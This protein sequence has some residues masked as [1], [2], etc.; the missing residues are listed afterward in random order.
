MATNE[1]TEDYLEEQVLFWRKDITRCIQKP[2][3]VSQL[4]ALDVISH[5][6]SM[7]LHDVFTKNIALVAADKLI[8]AVYKSKA[9]N[10]WSSFLKALD[11]EGLV[12]LKE[13]IEEG[14]HETPEEREH[15]RKMIQIFAPEL[16]RRVEPLDLLPDLISRDVIDK[17]DAEAVR[18][19]QA[20][21]GRSYA[22]VCMYRRMQS[23]LR[24][25]K[26]YY[27]FLCVLK[28]QGYEDILDIM[29]PQFLKSPT[30]Y[31]PKPGDKWIPKKPYRCND[32]TEHVL[33]EVHYPSQE[34]KLKSNPSIWNANLN[35]QHRSPEG[36]LYDRRTEMMSLEP[37]TISESTFHNRDRMHFALAHKVGQDLDRTN[38]WSRR[39]SLSS[40][41]I[42]SE[43]CSHISDEASTYDGPLHLQV[44]HAKRITGNR[45]DMRMNRNPEKDVSYDS[46]SS[47]FDPSEDTD[48]FCSDDESSLYDDIETMEDTEDDIENFEDSLEDFQ[49]ELAEKALQGHNTII[50]SPTNTGKTYVALKIM[51]DHLV[52][53][54]GGRKKIAFMAKTVLLI[55]QQAERII[56]HLPDFNVK[57]ANAD[58]EESLALGAFME[59]VDVFCFTPQILVNN[60]KNGSIKRISEFSLLVFDECHHSKGY[61]PYTSLLHIYLLEKANRTVQNARLPQIVG[62]TASLPVG[63]VETVDGALD[64][65]INLCAMLDV[66]IISSVERCIE[67]LKK[68]TYVPNEEK[69]PL[70]IRTSDPCGKI[71]LEQLFEVEKLLQETALT[72]PEMVSVMYVSSTIQERESPAYYKWAMDVDRIAMQNVKHDRT[73]RDIRACASYI[74]IYAAALEIN[75]LLETEDIA[76][77]LAQR[78]KRDTEASEKL[79]ELES[80]LLRQFKRVQANLLNVSKTAGTNPNVRTVCDNLKE[81][82]SK[83]EVGSRA[84]IMVKARVTSRALARFINKDFKSYGIRAKELYGQADLGG[85]EG[86]DQTM[87]KTILDQ[88][89]KGYYKVLVCTSVGNEGLHT[90]GCNIVINYNVLGNETTKIQIP[91]RARKPNSTL[92]LVGTHKLFDHDRMN[93]FKVLLMN[94]AVIQFKAMDKKELSI[95]ISA[96]QKKLRNANISKLELREMKINRKSKGVDYIIKCQRCKTHICMSS[97]IR[98]LG[99][100]RFPINFEVTKHVELS[101]RKKVTSFDG[102]KLVKSAHCKRCP[103]QWGTVAE[104]KGLALIFLSC[105]AVVFESTG[106]SR[107]QSYKKWDDVPYDFPTI[108][109]ADIPCDFEKSWMSEL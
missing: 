39:P 65:I 56:K 5:D 79:T 103:V 29:E 82:M 64:S 10:K 20:N 87:Q 24:P 30:A 28:I 98:I 11:E 32:E 45:N 77:F 71:L 52:N 43:S 14:A 107:L 26:W 95:R 13:L 33:E 38:G 1:L 68:R 85:E 78:N 84:M 23:R 41:S 6:A 93:A 8:K 48:E 27:E 57:L 47:Q 36:W 80:K 54:P 94:Q 2:T 63:K 19:M 21:Y 102:I 96:Q 109:A 69:I 42:S 61:G 12:Y 60:L 59:M 17:D 91:G 88:F 90:P 100:G 37:E 81:M 51:K 46:S 105:V 73:R 55:K 9:P 106:S 3:L 70:V 83:D 72:N 58:S 99:T 44:D 18:M 25:A 15:G 31:I 40:M 101:E 53:H 62:L 86:M 89:N 92:V 74:T 22:V 75:T 67:S 104:T 50:W 97:E 7:K 4:A 108:D 34:T 16:E 66:K 49:L 76:R 35:T